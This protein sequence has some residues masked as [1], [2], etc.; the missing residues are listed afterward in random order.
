MSNL[1]YRKDIDG[2]RALAVLL[3]VFFHLDVTGIKSG[4]LGVDI[5]FVISGYLITSI[6]IRDLNS[7]NF[8]LKNFYLRRMRRILP[9]LITVLVVT[10]FFAWLLLLP[11]DLKNYSKSLVSALGSFSNLF[12]Y[13]TLNFGYF[14]TDASTI[15]LLHTWSLGIEEQF[16]LFWP[17]LLVLVCNVRISWKNGKALSLFSKLLISCLVL[18]ALSIF[19]FYWKSAPKYY[20]FPVTR[21]FELLFGCLLAIYLSKHK[22]THNK[23]VT[24]T[25]SIIALAFMFVPM[26]MIHVGYPSYWTVVACM[27]AVMYIY[28]GSNSTPIVNRIFS[29]QPIVAIGLI[30]YSL[31][32]WHWPIIAY[33]NYLSIEKTITVSLI[34]IVVSILLATLT[35]FFVEKPFRHGFKFSFTKTLLA[36]WIIPI[37]LASSFALCSKYVNEFGFNRV[38]TLALKQSEGYYGVLKK[39]YGCIDNGKESLPSKKLCTIGTKNTNSNVLL[40]GDSHA[41]ADV[42]ML[43][44]WLKNANLTA[45]VATNSGSPFILGDDIQ[46]WRANNPVERS[47]QIKK[48]IQNSNYKYV[49]MASFWNYYPNL[50]TITKNGKKPFSVLY[51]GLR[52]AVKFVV[53]KGSTPVLI[54]DNPSTLSLKKI[55][56]ITRI[57]FLNCYNSQSE[58]DKSQKT[59]NDIIDKIKIEFP[60]VIVVSP[61]RIICEN[62]KCVTSIENIP[63]Y[64]SD[65]TNS[66]LSYAGSTLIGELY[67]KRF[68]NP[69]GSPKTTNKP[70]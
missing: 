45:Y 20:Y 34:I 60:S 29:F 63:L 11:Q 55:C 2:L 47:I 57:N 31:Y 50:P 70:M 33:L 49:V 48:L 64:M 42:G 7:G 15:P 56:G 58:I 16:Y 65:G 19:C 53:N 10:A 68:G 41:M 43:N 25:L 37:V 14:S 66:H 62:D 52:N 8:S 36:L 44:V 40:V 67:I 3:V 21:A 4:F 12:F 51:S 35:Y 26:L 17:L 54:K 22:M 46:S 13:K 6:I 23:V 27:G 69:L 28:A 24:N 61:S 9:A 30:S 18:I 32:L 5:F 39:S 1:K 59:V 38:P